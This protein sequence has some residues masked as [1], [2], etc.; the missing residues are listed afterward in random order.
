[1]TAQHTRSRY[2]ENKN[3]FRIVRY[4]CPTVKEKR[5]PNSFLSNQNLA[6]L[7]HVVRLSQ[8]HAQE[9]WVWR[10]HYPVRRGAVAA[11]HKVTAPSSL[12]LPRPQVFATCLPVVP[13]PPYRS[14]LCSTPIIAPHTRLCSLIRVKNYNGRIMDLK[15]LSQHLDD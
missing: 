8:S 10:Q 11:G 9:V 5:N 2:S 13:C 7:A 14:T 3:C 15:P 4:R 6:P 1:M 12:C